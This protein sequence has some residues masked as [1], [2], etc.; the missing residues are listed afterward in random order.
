MI[1]LHD[2]RFM[3]LGIGGLLSKES[4]INVQAASLPRGVSSSKD[5][6]LAVLPVQDY[7]AANQHIRLESL[8][9]WEST[10]PVTDVNEH[11]NREGER[12]SYRFPTHW[13]TT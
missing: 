8:L 2:G 13:V 12:V 6:V 10:L 7:R 4:G 3:Y 9:V 1:H 11:Q 5:V